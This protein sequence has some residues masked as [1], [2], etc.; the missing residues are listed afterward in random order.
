MGDWAYRWTHSEHRHLMQVSGVTLAL[1]AGGGGRETEPG[2]FCMG[3]LV[4]PRYPME[5]V[6]K[7]EMFRP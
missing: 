5:T 6:M 7:S 4:D 1:G 2:S 3:G